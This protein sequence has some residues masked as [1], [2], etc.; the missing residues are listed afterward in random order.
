MFLI[1]T[2]ADVTV[3]LRCQSSDLLLTLTRDHLGSSKRPSRQFDF[4]KEFVEQREDSTF[5]RRVAI[6]RHEF[7]VPSDLTCSSCECQSA[8]EHF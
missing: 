8:R 4:A 1:T 3:E 5:S 6:V 2:H 7:A